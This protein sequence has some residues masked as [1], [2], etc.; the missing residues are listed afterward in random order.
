MILK[1]TLLLFVTLFSIAGACMIARHNWRRYGALYFTSAVVGSLLCLLFVQFN[2]YSFPVTLIP[3]VPI[4]LTQMFTA[5]PLLV[6]LGVRYSPTRWPWKIPFYWAFVHIIMLLET[7]FLYKPKLIRYEKYWDVWT[8][9]TWW[10]IF[11]LV[12]E[13]VGGNIV[14]REDRNPIRARSFRYGRWAW[15]VLHFIVIITIF[16][17]GFYLGRVL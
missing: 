15:T 17:G 2:F 7:M 11:M 13:W 10:W 6:L 9:Y 16:L 14:P 8:S 12:F 4:P 5:L 1:K 3:N